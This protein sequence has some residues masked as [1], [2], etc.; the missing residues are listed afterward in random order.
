MGEKCD[1]LEMES[2]PHEP[3]P[4]PDPDLYSDFA[5]LEREVVE[6]CREASE[7]EGK[8]AFVMGGMTG[9]LILTICFGIVSR[10]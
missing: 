4:S 6:G 7:R 10:I 5:S 3:S 8:V 1:T 9:C 2:A